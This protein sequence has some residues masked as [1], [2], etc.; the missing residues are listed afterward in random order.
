MTVRELIT[1][2]LECDMDKEIYV[3]DDVVFENKDG[4]IN[5]SMYNIDSIDEANYVYL[6]IDNC[7][8]FK[9]KEQE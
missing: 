5:G 3:A 4:K 8:H 6:N 2:L 9:R 7:N 1:Q